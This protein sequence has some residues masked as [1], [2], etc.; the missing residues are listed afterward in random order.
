MVSSKH[1]RDAISVETDK[2]IKIMPLCVDQEGFQLRQ[3]N[4]KE[5]EENRKNLI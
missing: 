3:E 2:P 1:T 5:R 4:N